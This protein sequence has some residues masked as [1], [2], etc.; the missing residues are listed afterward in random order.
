MAISILEAIVSVLLIICILVQQR[1]SGLT[2]ATGGVGTYVQ[3][4]GAEKVL[5]QA[6]YLFSALFFLLIIVDWFI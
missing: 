5:Y 2:N 1:S 6:T 4:R 3:R